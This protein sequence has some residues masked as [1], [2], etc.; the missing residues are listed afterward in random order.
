MMDMKNIININNAVFVKSVMD[1]DEL[2][3][4]SLPEIAFSGKSNVGKSS[5]INKLLNRKAIARISAT[6][7]KTVMLNFFDIDK[8]LHFVDLPGYGYAKRS[9]TQIS[10][11]G[12]IIDAYVRSRKEL[13]LIIQ[14]LDM[15][16]DPTQD[17]M[18]MFQWLKSSNKKFILAATKSDKLNKSEYVKR[19]E[20]LKKI[21]KTEVIP[22]SSLTG[23]GV[24]EIWQIIIDAANLQA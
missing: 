13:K 14:L 20:T 19:V 18:L 3:N 6:P 11:W 22:F 10:Q 4:N 7:G 24:D 15:R 8:K 16:H 5:M 2:P 23:N 9:N 1:L 21:T 17:D 12:D